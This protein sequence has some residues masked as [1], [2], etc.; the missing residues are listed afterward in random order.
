MMVHPQQQQQK[1]ATNNRNKGT[2]PILVKEDDPK[3]VKD[4]IDFLGI[5]DSN[6][7]EYRVSDD[8][9]AIFV[10]KDLGKEAHSFSDYELAKMTVKISTAL[11]GMEELSVRA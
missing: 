11:G 7:L 3:I 8:T 1:D 10:T 2:Q 9:A 5:P 4:P 6:K